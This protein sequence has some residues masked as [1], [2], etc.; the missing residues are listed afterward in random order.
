MTRKPLIFSIL[1]TAILLFTAGCDDLTVVR[2]DPAGVHQ[3]TRS[4]SC[5]YSG[6]CYG[7]NSNGKYGFGFH[8]SC[9]GSRQAVVSVQSYVVRYKSGRISTQEEVSVIRYL[10]N[11][12]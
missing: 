1:A 6:Y 5:E 4:V 12:R 10:T 8:F 7:M 11:C 2:R 9:S 3:E